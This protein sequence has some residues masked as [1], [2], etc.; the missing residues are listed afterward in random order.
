MM[1]KSDYMRESTPK[2]PMQFSVSIP[3]GAWTRVN[4]WSAL[5]QMRIATWSINTASG[6]FVIAYGSDI[7]TV[8]NL[9]SMPPLNNIS[10]NTSPPELWIGNPGTAA[11]T[12]WIEVWMWE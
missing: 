4:R 9:T 10:E 2:Y 11:I 5:Q 7:A 1:S 6:T 12:V 3:A 8:P